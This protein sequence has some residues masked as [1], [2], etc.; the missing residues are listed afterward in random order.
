CAAYS[1]HLD[2]P[3]HC[4]TTGFAH[5]RLGHSD[6]AEWGIGVKRVGGNAVRHPPLLVIENI[7]SNDLEIVVGRVSKGPATV[8]VTQ[9]PDTRHICLQLVV[10]F[11]K[12]AP[13][14]ADTS[15]L[16][17]EVVG[18]RAASDRQEQVRSGDPRGHSA[19][20]DLSRDGVTVSR[21]PHDLAA[22]VGLDTFGVQDI[23]DGLGNVFVLARNQVRGEFD[24]GYFAAETS[25]DLCEF[26]ADIAAAQND[27]MRWQEIYVHNRAVGEVADIV[28]SGNRRR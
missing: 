16:K 5:V 25:I 14:H 26:K 9:R 19:V 21:H 2:R 20:G 28:K 27:E 8:A 12:A 13:V 3:D 22:D 4:G 1:L 7:R 10:Y 11:D 23:G 24:H 18:V 6:A 17:A 15:G